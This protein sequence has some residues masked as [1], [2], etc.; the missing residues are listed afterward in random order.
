MR[1]VYRKKIEIHSQPRSIPED[2]KCSRDNFYRTHG[3]FRICKKK[4][5]RAIRGATLVVEWNDGETG[6]VG[7]GHAGAKINQKNNHEEL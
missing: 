2:L 5:L 7:F 3:T 4:M 1:K 6:S